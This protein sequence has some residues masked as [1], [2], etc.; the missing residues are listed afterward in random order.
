MD[1]ALQIPGNRVQAIDELGRWEEAKVLHYDESSKIV[2]VAFPG[3][4]AEFNRMVSPAEIRLPR[5]VFDEDLESSLSL[6]RRRPKL[7]ESNYLSTLRQLCIDDKIA[8][9]QNGSVT[10]GFV[11]VVDRFRR[12][13]TLHLEDGTIQVI[14]ASLLVAD[15]PD[16]EEK[17]RKE[18]PSQHS[19]RRLNKKALTG[20]GKSARQLHVAVQTEDSGRSLEETLCNGYVPPANSDITT[21]KSEFFRAIGN[22]DVEFSCGDMVEIGGLNSSTV[23]VR[24]MYGLGER[25]IMGHPVGCDGVINDAITVSAPSSQVRKASVSLPRASTN[26]LRKFKN[27]AFVAANNFIRSSFLAQKSERI[28]S[29]RVVAKKEL[30]ATLQG[31]APRKVFSWGVCQYHIDLDIFRIKYPGSTR[32]VHSYRLGNLHE[33]DGI[34]EDKWDVLV[35]ESRVTFVSEIVIWVNK[36]SLLNA[37]IKIATVNLDVPLGGNYRKQLARLVYPSGH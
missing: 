21:M 14:H 29:I 35:K 10:T 27:D 3:W 9:N 5:S 22:D 12:E 33:L 30:K 34:F 2:T 4:G 24:S 26:M 23:A 8:F 13:I 31:N 16:E 15:H 11:K 25:K 32:V 17:K 37:S 18:P 1:Q 6:K 20:P 28:H 7:R 36:D 19:R